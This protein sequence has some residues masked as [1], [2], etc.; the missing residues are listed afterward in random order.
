MI[1][2]ST[3]F[4]PSLFKGWVFLLLKN[5]IMEMTIYKH[6]KDGK[7]YMFH[8]IEKENGKKEVMAIPVS[9]D[10]K[11]IVNCDTNDFVLHS[12]EQK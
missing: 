6:R 4:K 2:Y 12:I 5:K 1:L 9:H 11:P 7:L 3:I 8:T 10:G